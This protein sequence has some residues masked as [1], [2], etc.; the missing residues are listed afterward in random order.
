MAEKL[1]EA[2]ARGDVARV[3]RLLG[4]NVKPLPDEV[5]PS[6]IQILQTWNVYYKNCQKIKL[7][8]IH[9]IKRREEEEIEFI[10]YSCFDISGRHRDRAQTMLKK[11]SRRINRYN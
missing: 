10:S 5:C 2:A 4:E 11:M 6:L 8:N 1:C 9:S 7:F 3:T